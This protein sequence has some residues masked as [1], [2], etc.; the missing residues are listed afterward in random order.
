MTLLVGHRRSGMSLCQNMRILESVTGHNYDLTAPGFLAYFISRTGYRIDLCICG[1]DHVVN[2]CANPRVPA[3]SPD[4]AVTRGM[5]QD[6]WELWQ[7][8]TGT[9]KTASSWAHGVGHPFGKTSNPLL[10]V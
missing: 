5:L 3:P 8:S 2:V 4:W 6:C 9:K 1:W 10:A 7:I